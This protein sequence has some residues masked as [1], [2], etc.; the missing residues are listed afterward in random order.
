MNSISCLLKYLL[1]ILGKYFVPSLSLFQTLMK[2]IFWS[3][4]GTMLVPHLEIAIFCK[5]IVPF[6]SLQQLWKAF[7]ETKAQKFVCSTYFFKYL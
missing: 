7:H 1:K 3:V 6:L 5:C 4:A 2:L